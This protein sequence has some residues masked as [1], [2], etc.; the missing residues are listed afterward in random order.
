MIL[1]YFLTALIVGPITFMLIRSTNHLRR[2]LI[3]LG[4]IV[5]FW[6][7]ETLLIV[8]LG[9]K[10]PAGSTPITP[11]DLKDPDRK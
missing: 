7:A 10:P 1:V 8:R 2:V 3:A 4:V 6:C 11:T 9:D 5:L